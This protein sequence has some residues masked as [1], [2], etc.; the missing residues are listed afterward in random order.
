[1]VLYLMVQ[2]HYIQDFFL[3]CTYESLKLY[4]SLVQITNDVC[5]YGKVLFIMAWFHTRQHNIN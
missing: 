2:R 3:L 4:I 1:M 5:K